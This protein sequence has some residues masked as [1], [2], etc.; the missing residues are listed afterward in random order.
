VT[1][2]RDW[3]RERRGQRQRAHGSEGA[4]EPS[5]DPGWLRGTERPEISPKGYRALVTAENRLGVSP[6]KVRKACRLP[7]VRERERAL[8]SLLHLLDANRELGLQAI[9]NH[10]LAK[11]GRGEL[12]RVKAEFVSRVELLREEILDALRPRPQGP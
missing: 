10:Y 5:A 8:L 4:Y 1:P 6:E 2:A 9:E 3:D 7:D 12:P 11:K